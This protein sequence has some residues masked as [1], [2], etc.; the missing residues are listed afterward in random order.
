MHYFTLSSPPMVG[1][2]SDG[3]D[4]VYLVVSQQDRR[5]NAPSPT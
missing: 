5:L 4:P 1:P 2:A 3:V